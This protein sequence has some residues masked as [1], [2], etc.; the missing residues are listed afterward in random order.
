MGIQQCDI[1]VIIKM[2]YKKIILGR[3]LV[4][5]EEIPIG[6]MAKIDVMSTPIKVQCKKVNS[7]DC[8]VIKSPTLNI[9]YKSK[10][11]Y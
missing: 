11:G 8:N 2:H 5:K 6:V 3:P 7:I 1:V 10:I 9:T 4:S